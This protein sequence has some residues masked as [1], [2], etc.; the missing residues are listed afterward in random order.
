MARTRFNS[1]SVSMVAPTILCRRS[2]CRGAPT[3][4]SLRVPHFP[5]GP[6]GTCG[7]REDPHVIAIRL[8]PEHLVTSGHGLPSREPEHLAAGSPDLDLLAVIVPKNRHYSLH[9]DYL[10]FRP[11]TTFAAA[12]ELQIHPPRSGR[13]FE[14]VTRGETAYQIY[15]SGASEPCRYVLTG[16]EDRE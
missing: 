2:E 9:R 6:P 14:G 7:S 15:C 8:D 16:G 1:P 3:G 11:K 12:G 13:N 10:L 5:G 4:A